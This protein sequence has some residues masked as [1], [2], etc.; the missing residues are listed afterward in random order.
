MLAEILTRNRRIRP[1]VHCIANIVTANDCAN[2]LL[3]S[4][5]SPIMA[6]DP[7][8]VEEIVSICSGL[9]LNVG[10]PNPR[11][12]EALLRAGRA[13][14][15]LG[16]PVILDPVGVGSSALRRDA[17]QR[18]LESVHFAIIRGNESEIC[19]MA[20]GMEARRGVDADDRSHFDETLSLARQLARNSGAIVVASGKAD[21]VTDGETACRVLNG[22]P[23][24]R[25]VT[26]TGCQ[27]SALA[28]AFAAS[29]PEN[30]RTAAL[31]ATCAMGLCGEIAHRRLTPMDGNASY[32]NYIIDALFNL[33]PGVLEKEARYEIC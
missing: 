7:D 24:M 26:G 16:L 6:E 14:N 9:V 33:E 32:R 29:N 18:L 20:C 21:I 12:I 25:F 31:A 11:K 15:R 28:G 1:L 8:E 5:A 3:A 19:T 17:V 10:T 13:A 2:L 23:M 22:H 30:L 27:L 4:G